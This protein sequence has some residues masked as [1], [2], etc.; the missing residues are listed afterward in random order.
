M[1]FIQWFAECIIY[2][3]ENHVGPDDYTWDINNC[4]QWKERFDKGMSP[5]EAVMDEFKPMYN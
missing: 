5:K 3:A 4:D 2:C 1:E